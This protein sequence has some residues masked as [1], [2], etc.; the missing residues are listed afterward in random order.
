MR[1]SWL[2]AATGA[3][4]LSLLAAP[5]L[6][7]ATYDRA[8]GGGQTLVGTGGAGNTIAFSAQNTADGAKGEVQYI[9]RSGGT[10]QAQV[11]SHGVVDCLSVTGNTAVI[12]G[13]WTSGERTG[14]FEIKVVDNGQG[15]AA[16]NDVI[17]IDSAAKNNDCTRDS[18]DNNTPS[19]DLARG[20][21]QVYD[22]P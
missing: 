10:G 17:T 1:K 16:S 19:A 4:A 14:V 15:A 18:N 12:G 6:A 9:D 20:N 2:A 13:H 21:A 8:T 22:A 3:A 5:A 11:Q 7:G